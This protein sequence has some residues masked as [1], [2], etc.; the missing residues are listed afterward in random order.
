M[1]GVGSGGGGGSKDEHQLPNL[2]FQKSTSKTPS[3]KHCT[4]EVNP[5]ILD[6]NQPPKLQL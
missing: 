5:E 1:L 2:K 6:P 4:P 3:P